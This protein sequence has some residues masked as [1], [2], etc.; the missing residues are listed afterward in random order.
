[1][2]YLE[3]VNMVIQESGNEL[4][5]LDMSTFTSAVAGQRLY[6]RM[7][8]Y[9]MQ[10]W[11]AIQMSR[12]EWEFNSGMVHEMVYPR[13]RFSAGSAGASP[14][15][16]DVFVG[17]ESGFRITVRQVLLDSGLFTTDD[18]KGQI[19]FSTFSGGTALIDGEVYTDE[20]DPTAF[21]TYD[22]PG[23]YDFSLTTTDLANVQWTSFTGANNVSTQIPIPYVPWA[24]WYFAQVS[25]HSQSSTVPQ[26]VSQDNEGRV[27][28]FPQ[29]QS[30]FRVSFVYTKTPQELTAYNDVPTDLPLQYHEWIAW[31][32]LMRLATYDKN[33]QLFA[34]SQKQAIFFRNRA[35][36]NLMPLISYR[37]SPFNDGRN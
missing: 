35:E 24:N 31:E 22:R 32:A 10:A 7:K 27:V 12:D 18:A 5:E 13:I 19:E 20:S 34:H 2:N 3:L 1:M 26:Y 16:G 36:K 15:V 14:S 9:V 8:R 28:F 30:P 25:Y 17:A 4:N 29:I 37:D 21:F 33:S 6:P 23:D 11:K